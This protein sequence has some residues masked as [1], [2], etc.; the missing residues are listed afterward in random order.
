M[1]VLK[2]EFFS[3]CTSV[4]NR[5]IIKPSIYVKEFALGYKNMSSLTISIKV[6]EPLSRSCQQFY[7]NRI[8]RRP[9][10]DSFPIRYI[11]NLMCK[12]MVDSVTLSIAQSEMTYVLTVRS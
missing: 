9:V 5:C 4:W 10:K 6:D 12:I 7:K 2:L 8:V 1:E 11:Q 3:S